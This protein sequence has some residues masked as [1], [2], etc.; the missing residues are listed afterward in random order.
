MWLSETS[1]QK[2]GHFRG[3][4]LVDSEKA[5]NNG[6]VDL[7]ELL[8]AGVGITHKVRYGYQFTNK[9]WKTIPLYVALLLFRSVKYKPTYGVN[10][11]ENESDILCIIY[12]LFYDITYILGAKVKDV[13]TY[14]VYGWCLYPWCIWRMFVHMVCMEDVRTYGVY[15][16]CLHIWCV[17]RMAV[18]M[19]YMEDVC[20]HG[21]YGGCL[22]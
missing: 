16:D 8:T 2:Y 15:G 1:N 21:V 4:R 9:C 22:H 17:W 13:C 20:M 12:V 14:G 10:I 11:K 6:S 5:Q 19:V 3:L 7:I 18:P